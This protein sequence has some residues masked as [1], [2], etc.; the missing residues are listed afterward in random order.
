LLLALCETARLVAALPPPAEWKLPPL[1]GELEGEINPLLLGGAP[2]V[3]W[4]LNLRTERPRERTVE[5]LLEGHGL[6]LRGDVRV[7][8]VLEGSWRLAEAEVDLGVWFG[9]LAPRV[10]PE[11]GNLTVGGVC[12]ASGEGTWLGGELAGRAS[13]SLREGLFENPVK[14]VRL[15][16]LA[17]SVTMEDL[18]ARR[19]AASQILTW[20]GGHYDIVPLGAGR[21]EFQLNGEQ[22][23]IAQAAIAVFGGELAVR[24][25]AFSTS[26]PEF[27]VSAQMSGVDVGQLLFLLPKILS[28]AS[29]R[30]DGYVDLARDAKGIA[31]GEGYLGLREGEKAQLKFRPSP[32]VIS[33]AL[34]P[35]INKLYPGLGQMETGGIPMEAEVLQIR[36]VPRGDEEHRTAWVHIAGRPVDPSFTGPIDLTVN[37]RGPLD[38]VFNT[39]ANSALRLMGR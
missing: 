20:T 3:K 4:K 37:I 23:T 31:I 17:F 29:G 6:R 11:Y 34:P 5:F 25:V 38:E 15:E 30:L 21:I 24:S 35:A 33:A 32:G 1:D 28:Q 13:V 22:V 9:W 8:P 12:T 7:N 14:K 39:G 18:H 10:A 36:F 16:G 2:R 27:S 19:T 26:R